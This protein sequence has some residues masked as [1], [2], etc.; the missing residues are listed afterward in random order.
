MQLLNFIGEVYGLLV[1]HPGF[2]DRQ[3]WELTTTPAVVADWL[4][5]ELSRLLGTKNP[6]LLI[7]QLDEPNRECVPEAEKELY[8]AR[9]HYLRRGMAYD[10]STDAYD[11]EVCHLFHLKQLLPDFYAAMVSVLGRLNQRGIWTWDDFDQGMSMDWF[12]EQLSEQLDELAGMK[13]KAEQLSKRLENEKLTKEVHD[14]VFQ[15]WEYEHKEITELQLIVDTKGKD[16][17]C[18]RTGDAAEMLDDMRR[19]A[20]MDELEVRR[21]L[22]DFLTCHPGLDVLRDW[23]L[24]AL[25]FSMLPHHLDEFNDVYYECDNGTVTAFE[26]YAIHWD[27][28]DSVFDAYNMNTQNAADNGDILEMVWFERVYPNADNTAVWNNTNQCPDWPIRLHDLFVRA[29]EVIP[30][31]SKDIIYLSNQKSTSDAIATQ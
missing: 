4:V 17:E 24:D 27:G 28:D 8:E 18:Y 22:T 30:A 7:N 23:L 20:D 1:T 14:H 11:I 15:Q 29:T 3:D 26:R 31:T 9:T 6:Y 2:V 12:M 19:L 21:I 5:N 25:D 10:I 16:L 13:E